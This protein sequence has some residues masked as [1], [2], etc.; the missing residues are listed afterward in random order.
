[1]A[2]ATSRCSSQEHV[3]VTVRTRSRS[4]VAEV[5]V[6][7]SCCADDLLNALQ[8]ID[9]AVVADARR[10]AEK[11]GRPVSCREGCA[12][13]CRHLVPVTVNE[14][15]SL[16]SLVD[17]LPKGQRSRIRERFSEARSRLAESGLLE[18]VSQFGSDGPWS[19]RRLASVYFRMGIACPFLDEER[20][21]I[22]E[23]RPLACREYLV[24]SPAKNC[25]E[26]RDVERLP[27]PGRIRPRLKNGLGGRAEQLALIVALHRVADDP[28][29]DEQ[30]LHTGA[31]KT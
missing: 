29:G 20:C 28:P 9:D 11:S 2:S 23:E 22:Y 24:T 3:R 18:A 27:V 12:A 10:E 21:T 7:T 26:A 15:R 14:A 1:M 25:T 31:H 4:I 6:P 8:V 13:C 19:E 16:A 17:S 30:P 5:D